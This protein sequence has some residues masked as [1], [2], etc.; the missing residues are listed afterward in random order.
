MVGAEIVNYDEFKECI[1]KIDKWYSKS[2]KLLTI[3]T[4]PYNSTLIFSKIISELIGNKK[5]ILYVWGK[6]G[7][8]FELIN[9][10]K[11]KYKGI[12]YA[13]LEEG[14]KDVDITFT[15]F[16]SIDNIKGYYE[17][18]IID[19]ISCFSIVDK[20]MII[21]L[22]EKMYIYSK[23]I[24]LY[25][26]ENVVSMGTK[27][28]LAILLFNRP[29]VEPR[30]LNTRVNLSKDIPYSLYEYLIWFKSNRRRVVIYVNSKEQVESITH[31][32]SNILKFEGIKMI[33][34]IK[35]EPTTSLK[36]LNIHKDRPV[37]I[38]TNCVGAYLE[39]ITSKD[40]IVISS[41]ER[42]CS[43]KEIIYLCAEVT[44]EGKQGEVLLVSKDTSKDMD[45]SRK[46]SREFNRAIWEKKL[47]K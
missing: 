40:I 18:C 31:Y 42:F 36:S 39:E 14:K 47:L 45:I 38:I 19:D 30:V 16:N 25:S 9:D 23:R 5:R 43:Y 34:Y 6:K 11:C 7:S 1:T 29:F 32:Y 27:M 13:Y 46:I 22:I 8:N 26:I 15:H 17:L 21:E 41:N 37:F 2:S 35:N 4:T 24:I 10:V 33:K 20:R 12:S 3:K 28:D 44:K